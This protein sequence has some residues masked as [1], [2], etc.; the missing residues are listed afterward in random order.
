[1]KFLGYITIII[2]FFI[3]TDMYIFYRGQV[4]VCEKNNGAVYQGGY[5][6]GVD[7]NRLN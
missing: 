5:C 3:C 6:L 7:G 4:E 1:M 2:L